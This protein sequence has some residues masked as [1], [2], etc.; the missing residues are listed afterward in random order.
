MWPRDDEFWAKLIKMLINLNE[1]TQ[2]VK[3]KTKIKTK[4]RTRVKTKI[5]CDA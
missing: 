3:I 1:E 4:I 2:R 5:K